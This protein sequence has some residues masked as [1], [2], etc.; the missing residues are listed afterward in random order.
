[1]NI[2]IWHIIYCLYPNLIKELNPREKTICICIRSIWS[3][4]IDSHS[5]SQIKARANEIK[6]DGGKIEGKVGELRHTWKT[7]VTQAKSE[8][9]PVELTM[10]WSKSEHASSTPITAAEVSACYMPASEGDEH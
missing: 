3:V 10:L 5:E 1:M 4:F 7:E 8:D 9:R 2:N 6:A